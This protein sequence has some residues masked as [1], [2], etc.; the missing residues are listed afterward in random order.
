MKLNWLEANEWGCPVFLVVP[1][2]IAF[3]YIRI[4]HQEEK[5]GFSFIQFGISWLLAL[6]GLHF[7]SSPP[8]HP[9]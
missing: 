1:F 5:P 4:Q 6:V 7:L 3:P 8:P 9:G 2:D